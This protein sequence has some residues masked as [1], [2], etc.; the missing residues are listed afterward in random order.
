MIFRNSIA[1]RI[2]RNSIAPRIWQVAK[3]W[4]LPA[5]SLESMKASLLKSM[6]ANSDQ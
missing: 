1:P 4:T 3:G 6:N 5:S 2:F